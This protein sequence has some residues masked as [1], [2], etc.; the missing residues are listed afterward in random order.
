MEECKQKECKSEDKK[1]KKPYSY[2]TFLLPFEI[3]NTEG[4]FEDNLEKFINKE[5][6]KELEKNSISSFGAVLLSE[7]D[8]DKKKALSAVKYAQKQYFHENVM[9][10]IHNDGE[11]NIVREYEYKFSNDNKYIE[12]ETSRVIGKTDDKNSSD[13]ENEAFKYTLKVSNVRLKVYN[14]GIG[15]LI[16]ELYN[17][18]YRDLKSVKEINELARRISLPFIAKGE[19]AG[20]EKGKADEKPFMLCAERI[21]WNFL[22]DSDKLSYNF[23]EKSNLFWNEDTEKDIYVVDFLNDMLISSKYKKSHEVKTSLDDRMFTCCIIQNN[24]LSESY[25]L[26]YIKE[27]EK[28]SDEYNKLSE[29]L[30]EYIYIDK[31]KVCTAPTFSFRKNILNESMYHRWTE[32]GTVY[33]A[34][35]T[36]LVAITGEGLDDIIIRPF[37][38]QYVEISILALVQR[39]SILSFQRKSSGDLSDGKIKKLQA[40]YIN[41]RNQLHFFEVSSQEQG[42][43]LYELVRKQLY[44]EKEVESLEKNLQILYEKSNVDRTQK[45]SILGFVFSCISVVATVF[46]IASYYKADENCIPFL[47]CLLRY[48]IYSSIAIISILLVLL[49]WNTIAKTLCKLINK[50]K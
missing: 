8:K 42:I 44:V 21:S 35:H 3:K 28:V 17:D 34:S 13:K 48:P 24:S 30:Y 32:F 11:D 37:L 43:E 25:T 31:E 6:W 38:T 4:L 39:A 46:S 50:I 22:K 47:K 19:Q 15:I 33:G 12:L 5:N 27:A 20:A 16:L 18:E 29:S 10:A 41:Y 23:R 40:K 2:H 1:I 7:E 36:S 9:R 14:T 49:C 45:L 26:D